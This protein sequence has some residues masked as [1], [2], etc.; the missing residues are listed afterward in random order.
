MAITILKKKTINLLFFL[1]FFSGALLLRCGG[2][3]RYSCWRYDLLYGLYLRTR[4]APCLPVVTN[5]VVVVSV[6]SVVSGI[7][8]KGCHARS[9]LTTPSQPLILC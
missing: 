7:A 2:V 1:F 3:N 9:L 6:V 5:I 8:L 4:P